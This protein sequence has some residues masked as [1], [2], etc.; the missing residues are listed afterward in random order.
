[1]RKEVLNVKNWLLMQSTYA[2]KLGVYI[3]WARLIHCSTDPYNASDSWPPGRNSTVVGSPGPAVGSSRMLP[4]NFTGVLKTINQ[5]PQLYTVCK[6]M[7]I[8]SFPILCHAV[9]LLFSFSLMV[10]SKLKTRD[11][12]LLSFTSLAVSCTV[13]GRRNRRGQMSGDSCWEAGEA[14]WVLG[15]RG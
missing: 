12:G 2:W 6:L 7:Q 15:A 3:Y 4:R 11:L 8:H 1:M 10:G 14:G 5:E 9:C 13:S